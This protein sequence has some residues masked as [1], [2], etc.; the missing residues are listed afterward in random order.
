MIELLPWL[1][2]ISETML[3]DNE[4]YQ[5]Y[6]EDTRNYVH[7]DYKGQV[8]GEDKQAKCNCKLVTALQA[9]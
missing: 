4:Q 7:C 5:A 6:A 1:V 2:N 3:K 9:E 8:L